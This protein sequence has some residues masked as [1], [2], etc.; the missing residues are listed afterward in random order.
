VRKWTLRYTVRGAYDG[1]P[2]GAEGN[3]YRGAVLRPG[4][5]AA[6][7]EHIFVLPHGSDLWRATFRWGPLPKGWKVASRSR[8][9]R[10]GPADDGRRYRREHHARR[11]R[12]RGLQ[13][14]I[15]AASFASRCGDPGRSQATIWRM[16]WRVPCRVQRAFWGNDVKGPFLVTLFGI[17]GTGSSGGTGRTDAFAL[18]GT[19]DTPERRI[20][21]TIAHEHMHSWIPRRI[22]NSARRIG[23]SARSTGSARASPI[24]M[25]SAP[26]SNRASGRWKSSF[27]I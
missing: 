25:P 18:Y 15:P 12:R 14:S 23:G 24:S 16:C 1:E 22:G 20:R 17:E 13:P 11:C 7:G 26:C 19:P 6:L 4:W 2:K 21:R 8:T 10:H 3:P 5:F 9:W 27:P